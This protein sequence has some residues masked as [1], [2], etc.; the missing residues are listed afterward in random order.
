MN[1]NTP[2]PPTV[3]E[4]IAWLTQV[5]STTARSGAP[6]VAARFMQIAGILKAMEE[7]EGEPTDD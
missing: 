4:H 3:A 5:A 7:P 6:L 2:A 1:D